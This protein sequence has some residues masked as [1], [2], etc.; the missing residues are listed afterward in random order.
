MRRFALNRYMVLTPPIGWD[1]WPAGMV[2]MQAGEDW[3][4][5]TVSDS[6]VDVLI[7]AAGRA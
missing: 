3:L 2:S 7:S 4:P 6:A 1:S 5:S